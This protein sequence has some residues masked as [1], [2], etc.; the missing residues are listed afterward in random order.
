MTQATHA[1][2]KVGGLAFDVWEAGGREDPAVLM[3]HGFPQD[4]SC[5]ETWREPLVARGYRVIQPDQR[6]YSPGARPS[7]VAAYRLGEL[8]EDAVGL[9]D[10][11][12]IERV[13]VIGHDW[14]GAVGWGLASRYPERIRTLVVLSTPHPRALV[15]SLTRSRQLAMSWYMAI[16]QW[17][18]LA[19]R[20]LSPDGP[21]WSKLMRGLPEEARQRY[22]VRAGDP[23]AFSGMIAWY[24]AMALD[25]IRPSMHWRPITVPTMYAWGMRDPALGVV[26][27]T[28]TSLEVVG[29]YEF[30]AL[31]RHGHWL[32]ERAGPELMPRV[33]AHL[34]RS[35]RH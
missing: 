35:S 24:R 14:G 12:G 5:W 27:A 15:R 33:L 16:L 22:A 7:E 9:V 21:G 13:H 20:L 25:A 10:A 6:G 4:H 2:V 32:A 11:L 31:A 17:P 30:I 18:G 19:Y 28:D 34:W 29:H 3:L 1:V 26:A 23:Q 8:V